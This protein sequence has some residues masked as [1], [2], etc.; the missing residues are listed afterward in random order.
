[1]TDSEYKGAFCLCGFVGLFYDAGVKNHELGLVKR[2]NELLMSRGPDEEGYFHDDRVALGFKRLS[3]IDLEKGSQ[4]LSEAEGRYHIVFNGEI[5]NYIELRNELMELGYVFQTH[6]DTEVLLAVYQTYG[7]EGVKRLRGMFAFA[8]W[9]QQEQTLFCA[10]DPFG[11]KPFYYRSTMKGMIFASEKKSLIAF[12]EKDPVLFAPALQQ[13]LTFQ[14]VP[15]PITVVEGIQ[16]LEAGSTLTRKAGETPEIRTYWRPQFAPT[17]QAFSEKVVQIRKVMEDSVRVHMRSDVPVGCFLSGGIDSTIIVAL[18][19]EIHPQVKAFSV[20]FER[21]GYSEIELAKETAEFLN[22]N[23]Y[24]KLITPQE[25]LE[26]LPRI[27]W[28]MDEPLAD[29]AAI[30]LYFVSREAKAH[31]KVVLSGEGSDELFGG[32]NIYR[33]PNSLRIFE[34]MPEWIKGMLHGL[35]LQLPTG[36]K[37]KSFL[38]RGTT[39]LDQRYV[40]NAFIFTEEEKKKLL[41]KYDKNLSPQD[42]T[43]S[44]YEESKAYDKVAQMQYIDMNTWLKGDILVKADRM[45]MANS[46]ELRV[47]FLDKEVFSVAS[48]LRQEDKIQGQTTKRALREAFKEVL[49]PAVVSR[50]KLGFPVPI[51]YWL[52]NDMADWAHELIRESQTHEYLVK[53]E[54]SRLLESHRKGEADYGRRLWTILMFMMWHKVYMEDH[55]SFEV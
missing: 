23:H 5:Y 22:V 32:Y 41:C 42:V 10:R 19:K 16:V 37:G 44:Y 14:Y 1:M 51:S 8:I 2:M 7:E 12:D 15:E 26:E 9:D 55:L 18:A 49:P 29:P 52:R 13:Y 35:S 30:P 53:N 4:P 34:H 11:I 17:N 50:K 39:P 21:K 20:G 40:G 24:T 47:P 31:V 3:I 45:S 6:S 27:V 36:L 38:Y 33:E 48:T 43:K 46:L 54:A 28:H 25:F